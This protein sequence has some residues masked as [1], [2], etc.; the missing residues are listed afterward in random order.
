M[1]AAYGLLET[2]LG[3]KT[4][5]DARSHAAQRFISLHYRLLSYQVPIEGQQEAPSDGI[6]QQAV[7]TQHNE[8]IVSPSIPG[9]R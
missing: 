9:P 7:S 4:A 6:I 2:H 1:C 3:L 8:D 5:E